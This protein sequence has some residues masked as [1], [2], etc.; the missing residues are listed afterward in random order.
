MNDRTM[1]F[2]LSKEDK[3]AEMKKN[4]SFYLHLTTM[5]QK[6][7]QNRSVICMTPITTF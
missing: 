7:I 2:S 3:D 5:K 6:N 4:L 1:V